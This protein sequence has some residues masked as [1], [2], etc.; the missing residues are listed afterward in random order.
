MAQPNPQARLLATRALEAKTAFKKQFEKVGKKTRK[1]R[2]SNYE[3]H[4]RKSKQDPENRGVGRKLLILRRLL[5]GRTAGGE[6][7]NAN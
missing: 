3:E 5:C 6:L 4:I 1:R 2:K 7:K